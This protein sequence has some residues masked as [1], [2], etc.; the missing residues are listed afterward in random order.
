[1]RIRHQGR[2]EGKTSVVP[3]QPRSL[4][5]ET[6]LRGFS[7]TERDKA[8][9]NRDGWEVLTARGEEFGTSYASWELAKGRAVS[10]SY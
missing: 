10:L 5:S 6:S 8:R 3:H 4:V 7:Q 2:N 1:M 9:W